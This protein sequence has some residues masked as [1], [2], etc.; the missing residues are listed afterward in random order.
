MT[1]HE[2]TNGANSMTPLITLIR[3]TLSIPDDVLLTKISCGYSA[4]LPNNL[5]WEVTLYLSPSALDPS[6]FS[7]GNV[8]AF[9]GKHATIEDAYAACLI[10]LER[11]REAEIAK[12]ASPITALIAGIEIEL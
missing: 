9:S 10:E 3:S 11:K 2:L 12:R 5:G 4:S 8:V 7:L 1:D 6:G